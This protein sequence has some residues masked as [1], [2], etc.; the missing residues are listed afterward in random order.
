MG[1]HET[2][3][4]LSL[5]AANAVFIA[6]MVFS[7]V[8]TASGTARFS[9]ALGIGSAT[10]W[11]AGA[12]FDLAKDVLPLVL[13]ALVARR[14]IVLFVPLAVAWICLVAYS[15][16]ATVA[17]VRLAI[18]AIER[19]AAEAM[20]VRSGLE[21]ELGSIE[22]L[23]AALTAHVTPRPARV[24]R[25]A[26]A[27]EAVPPEVWRDSRECLGIRDS[28]YFQRACGKVL[29]LRRELTA[30]EEYERLDARAEDLR[31]RLAAT[32]I[33]PIS[34]PLPEA[35]EAT[36][37]S[38][39]PI[40]GNAGVALLLM[41]VI[42]ILSTLGTTA[43][44]YLR[45]WAEWEE[46]VIKTRAVAHREPSRGRTRAKLPSG[47][48]GTSHRGGR[49]IGGPGR[50]QRPITAARSGTAG[51]GK[52]AD[53][54]PH[55]AQSNAPASHGD[56][57][58]P[59]MDISTE[60]QGNGGRPLHRHNEGLRYLAAS[61]ACSLISTTIS[62][63]LATTW[64]PWMDPSAPW[65]G[66]FLVMALILTVI[67]KSHP[68]RIAAASNKSANGSFSDS[69]SPEPSGRWPTEIPR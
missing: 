40:T 64:P 43:M 68:G 27:A 52:A 37:G 60:S 10:G 25:E 22:Q 32:A 55:A 23:Q 15:C 67:L 36:L 65:R 61:A 1:E 5:A 34:D 49:P 12:V 47:A 30:A 14:A 53:P 39:L 21:S 19:G 13:R 54:I 17:T 58:R 24:V 18:G 57:G 38:W 2:W 41:V 8:I 16:L 20:Q 51:V 9:A 45:E 28:A 31:K 59:F 3:G 56:S 11:A 33:A 50:T 69:L 44:K 7:P 26:L 46:D 63:I 35:F 29:D 48:A 42:E 6:S 4:R 66:A 62:T